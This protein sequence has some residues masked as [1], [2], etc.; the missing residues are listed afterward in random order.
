MTGINFGRAG[1]RD[2]EGFIFAYEISS[3]IFCLKLFR[4]LPVAWI[5]LRD[6]QYIR[7]RSG[8]GVGGLFA[9]FFGHPF[10]SWYWP[11]PLMSFS[12]AEST[13]YVIRLD[14]GHQIF[15]RLRAGFHYRLRAAMGRVRADG[16]Q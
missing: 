5:H 13:A 14:S 8:E 16:N 1:Q 12:P 4:V 10:R 7:Q 6:I 2:R 15:V 9:E 3:E 11:H